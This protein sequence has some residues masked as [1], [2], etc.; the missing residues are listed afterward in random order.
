MM[1]VR[2]LKVGL[3]FLRYY[4][5]KVRPYEVAAQIWNSCDQRCIYCRCPEVATPLMTTDQW[6]VV[7]RELRRMGTIRIKFQGG[8]PTIKPDFSEL[9]WEA[10]NLGMITS[11]VT[12]GMRIASNPELLAPLKEVV[13]S[14]DSLRPEVNDYMRGEGAHEGAMKTIDFALERGLKTY[15]NMALCRKNLEDL[16]PM[17]TFCESKG[18]K[19]NAQPIKFGVKYYDDQARKIALSP[20][21]IKTFHLQ[22]VNWKKQGRGIMFSANSYRKALDWPDLTRNTIQSE[23]YSKCMAGNFYFHIDPNGDVIPDRKS[24]V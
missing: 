2:Q 13:V 22:M 10:R 24:V 4:L 23:E 17:L 18:M 14:L 5:N 6:R 11:T 3:R 7:L 1:K 9:C 21:Q 19:M 20:E 12:N 15:V 16:E 8:E